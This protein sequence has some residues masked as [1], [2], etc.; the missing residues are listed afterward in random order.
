MDMVILEGLSLWDL[1][2]RLRLWEFMSLLLQNFHVLL[3]V[4]IEDVVL[5][6]VLQSLYARN[7]IRRLALCG[8]DQSAQI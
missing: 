3:W 8:A 6:N 7:V 2:V 5:H 4:C 1:K